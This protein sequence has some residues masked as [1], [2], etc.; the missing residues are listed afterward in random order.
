MTYI[1]ETDEDTNLV[2]QV[3]SELQA[4]NG[5]VALRV[6]FDDETIRLEGCL[7]SSTAPTLVACLD[8]VGLETFVLDLSSLTS[9]DAVGNRT[10]AHAV[11]RLS[12][13]G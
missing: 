6:E 7:D 2:P 10:V 8:L 11:S 9:I 5:D 3:A 13:N 1:I 4:I 12:T